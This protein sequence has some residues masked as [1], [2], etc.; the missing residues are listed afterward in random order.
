MRRTKA[1]RR[2]R[3]RRKSNSRPPTKR[4]TA[5]N[6]GTASS[7]LKSPVMTEDASPSAGVTNSSVWL[8]RASL[9]NVLKLSI[10]RW[11]IAISGAAESAGIANSAGLSCATLFSS[12]QKQSASD[13]SSYPVADAS[14]INGE[15]SGLVRAATRL[16]YE[17]AIVRADCERSGVE[18]HQPALDSRSMCGPATTE[19]DRGKQA[20]P[21]RLAVSGCFLL[22][23]L[24]QV[25]ARNRVQRDL[26]NANPPTRA[27]DPAAR[28]G[29]PRTNLSRRSLQHSSRRAVAGRQS[30]VIFPGVPFSSG[31]QLL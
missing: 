16:D 20:D 26:G 15:R 13:P 3:R 5:A 24:W 21:P 8:S 4:A 12:S 2:W 6:P 14:N 23:V 31:N 1:A 7:M 29:H 9:N 17:G 27:G 19:K 18:A 22:K 10:D 25:Q 11:A 30:T 28:R